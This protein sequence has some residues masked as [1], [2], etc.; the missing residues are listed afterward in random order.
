MNRKRL[1]QLDSLLDEIAEERERLARERLRARRMEELF[2]V[3]C[4]F[5]VPDF[6]ARER[7]IAR[8]LAAYEDEIAEVRLWIDGVRDSMTRRALR[9][10]YLD[11]M[12][13][14]AIAMRMGYGSESGPR[15]LCAR[16]MERRE[17]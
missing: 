8:K 3:G 7:E 11:G 1:E 12:S 13:W 9:L 10:R 17:A 14:A 15:M 6:A 2:G 4:L 16:E 5:G